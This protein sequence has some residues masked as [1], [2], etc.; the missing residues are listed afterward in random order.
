[1]K[2]RGETTDTTAEKMTGAPVKKAPE[3]VTCRLCLLSDRMKSWG[4]DHGHAIM[5]S[6]HR[7]DKY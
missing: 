4:L 5:K 6:Q 2:Y 7:W 1:M 3:D